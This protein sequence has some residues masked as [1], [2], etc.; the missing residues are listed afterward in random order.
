M[1]GRACPAEPWCRAS[2]RIFCD[3]PSSWFLLQMDRRS[4][5]APCWTASA[6]AHLPRTL[7]EIKASHAR[8]SQQSQS[9]GRNSVAI[10]QGA[11]LALGVML[12]RGR[13]PADLPAT[14]HF[15]EEDDLE[16]KFG[17]FRRCQVHW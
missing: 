5:D 10:V 7:S 1:R 2:Q 17:A 11:V 4:K 6:T 15:P 8:R 13:S 14:I 9:I 12:I 3:S 16:R